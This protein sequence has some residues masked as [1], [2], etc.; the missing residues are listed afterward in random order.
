MP[1]GKNPAVHILE[2]WLSYQ[3]AITGQIESDSNQVLEA[4]DR[5]RDSAILRYANEGAD[6]AMQGAPIITLYGIAVSKVGG[7][8]NRLAGDKNPTVIEFTCSTAQLLTAFKTSA[9]DSGNKCPFNNA[10]QLAARYSDQRDLLEKA[11][12]TKKHAKK[13]NGTTH[14]TMKWIEEIE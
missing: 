5:F 10:S 12:W 6:P 14:Y 7:Y 9:K 13:V 2:Q 1:Q 11:G 4:L 3:D 8:G